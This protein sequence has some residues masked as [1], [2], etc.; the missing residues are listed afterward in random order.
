MDGKKHMIA[1]IRF[2]IDQVERNLTLEA[3]AR[4]HLHAMNLRLVEALQ[5]MEDVSGELDQVVDEAHR[6]PRSHLGRLI[7]SLKALIQRWRAFKRNQPQALASLKGTQQDG[8]RP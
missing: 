2:E 4:A 5:L 1:A 8:G 6:V 7:A 3:S